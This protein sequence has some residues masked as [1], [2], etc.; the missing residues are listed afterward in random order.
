M[1]YTLDTHREIV[2]RFVL[3]RYGK[4][5]LVL[6]LAEHL[7]RFELLLYG[8]FAH[9][10]GAVD[11]LRVITTSAAGTPRATQR[12]NGGLFT[13]SALISSFSA[14][15]RDL[16]TCETCFS[17]AAASLA[18]A[19]LS[20]FA[21]PA[22]MAGGALDTFMLVAPSM[23]L[24]LSSLSMQYERNGVWGAPNYGP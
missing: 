7:C 11:R 12:V 20:F 10:L 18:I 24:L 8:L 2:R 5:V 19:F 9:T 1:A 3:A 16:L 21:S 13:F 6:C 14:D 17:A 23:L 4:V 22:V 15:R